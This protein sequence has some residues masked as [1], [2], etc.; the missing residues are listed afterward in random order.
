MGIFVGTSRGDV[1]AFDIA[2][3]TQWRTQLDGPVES[4]PLVV[5]DRVFVG[6]LSGAVYALNQVN[7]K[8]LWKFQGYGAFWGTLLEKDGLLYVLTS[9]NKL[10]VL[11]LENGRLHWSREHENARGYTVR[12]QS[13][14]VLAGDRLIYGLSSGQLVCLDASRRGEILW[15]VQLE[16][17]TE[18][19]YLDSD[20]TPIVLG[21]RVYT[22][23]FRSGI[24]AVSLQ[25]GEVLWRY[26]IEGV[27]R[28]YLHRER[29]YF[30]S[31]SAGIHCMTLD[32]R[33]LWR[34]QGDLGTVTGLHVV[35]R[36]LLISFDQSGLLALD[37][38]TGFFYQKFDTGSGLSGGFSIQRPWVSALANNGRLYLFQLR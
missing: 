34:Q 32:G 3:H 36:R 25:T 19:H 38:E 1:W 27:T 9:L 16:N 23:S 5:K 8:I 35:E 11:T 30:V 12:G 37:P 20:V 29:L 14:P 17:N 6:T 33:I 15:T 18:E 2:G 21:D 13:S 10:Y 22:A 24:A 7:G 4:R 31:S 28:M 26:P